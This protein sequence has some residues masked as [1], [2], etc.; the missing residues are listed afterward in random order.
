MNATNSEELESMTNRL[1]DLG[2]TV[3]ARPL[4]WSPRRELAVVISAELAK[5]VLKPVKVRKYTETSEY[6]RAGRYLEHWT[7]GSRNWCLVLSLDSFLDE[8]LEG[9]RGHGHTEVLLYL[10]DYFEDRLLELLKQQSQGLGPQVTLCCTEAQLESVRQRAERAS[11]KVR[12]RRPEPANMLKLA[13]SLVDYDAYRHTHQG[14]LRGAIAALQ[15][16]EDEAVCREIF[17]AHRSFIFNRV[18]QFGR[19]SGYPPKTGE[20]TVQGRLYQLYSG[21]QTEAWRKVL[22]NF[23]L[24]HLRKNC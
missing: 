15:K 16:V 4:F 24:D 8:L 21:A 2:V 14:A 1:E 23:N 18:F 7:L 9:L 13:R 5:G 3:A 20:S 22:A 11:E 19:E 6:G 10:S 12:F 17:Q